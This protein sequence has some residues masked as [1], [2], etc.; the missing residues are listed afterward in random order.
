MTDL[1]CRQRW[2]ATTAIGPHAIPPTPLLVRIAGVVAWS[3]LTITAP[4]LF[5]FPLRLLWLYPTLLVPLR[6][7]Q[8]S[9]SYKEVE[10]Q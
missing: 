6:N 8:R 4:S 10:Q 9:V 2:K 1:I 7:L 5:F 3:G